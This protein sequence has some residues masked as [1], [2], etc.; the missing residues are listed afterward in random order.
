[1]DENNLRELHLDLDSKADIH[2]AY[3]PFIQ[4]GGLFVATIDKYN[5]DQQVKLNV[6][7]MDEPDEF[8]VGGKVVWIT[9]GGAQNG[10]KAGVGVQLDGKESRDLITKIEN[11]LAGAGFSGQ[12]SDTL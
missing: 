11:L 5:I 7:L 1:M 6:K 9:P 10:M 12:R 2:A 3:M 4:Q 8:N